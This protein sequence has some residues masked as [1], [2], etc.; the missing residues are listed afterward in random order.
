MTV[1]DKII[2]LEGLGFKSVNAFV[3]GYVYSKM[4]RSDPEEDSLDTIYRVD[5][6]YCRI[7]PDNLIW[8]KLVWELFT[9]SDSSGKGEV[10]FADIFESLTDEQKDIAIFNFDLLT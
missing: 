10:S 5:T 6:V 2:V 8:N 4:F 7:Y 9:Y 1:R 3:D